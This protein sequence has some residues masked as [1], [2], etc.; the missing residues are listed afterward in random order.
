VD[1]KKININL[2]TKE[3]F[4]LLANLSLLDSPDR[5]LLIFVNALDKLLDEINISYDWAK[6]E[7]NDKY[8]I[9]INTKNKLYGTI[10][11]TG[12]IANLDKEVID[13]IQKTVGMLAVIL[14]SIEQQKMLFDENIYHRQI[15]NEKTDFMNS[16]IEMFKSLSENSPDIILRFDKNSHCLYVNNKISLLYDEN[17][18]DIE[19]KC[20][21]ETNL[22]VKLKEEIWNEIQK[23]IKKKKEVIKIINSSAEKVFEFHFIPEF[24]KSNELITVL[25][26]GRDI[27][28][29]Y[30]MEQELITAKEKAI[31]SDK[32]KLAFL[33]NI[34][35][36]I[37]TPL[38]G[39]IGFARLLTRSQVSIDK[40]VDYLKIIESSTN[41]LL[42]T[43]SNILEISKIESGEFKIIKEEIS[44]NEVI[45]DFF[46]EY[47]LQCTE[48]I[49]SEI[50]FELEI[51]STHKLTIF[52]DEYRL[53]EVLF[54]LVDN[55][56]KFTKEGFIRIGYIIKHHNIIFY[57]KDSGIGIKKNNLKLIFNRFYQVDYTERK[58][59]SGLGLGLTI[60]KAFIEWMGGKI[61]IESIYRKGTTIYFNL[62]LS[63]ENEL[64][65][66]VKSIKNGFVKA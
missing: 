30:K 17:I 4:H 54:N 12:N 2:L 51:P 21:K 55:A 35:H 33:A 7:N 40:K 45:Q 66:Q 50:K 6:A 27:T 16:N 20:L 58:E 29:K 38:N 32:L 9:E 47:K 36:E 10:Y 5:I 56:F 28:D 59:Y 44:L 18:E 1:K 57:I 49:K 34:S 62:P 25:S 43:V 42:R 19:G 23:V 8:Y 41:H 64:I 46:K 22:P 11:F 24:I 53:R 3:L 60:S 48:G 63:N 13:I 61:W 31:E 37:R 26:F 65:N 52:N 15:L 14:Q 39:I